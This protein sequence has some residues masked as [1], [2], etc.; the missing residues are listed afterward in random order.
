MDH[1]EVAWVDQMA[2]LVADP[3]ANQMITDGGA[4]QSQRQRFAS[5]EH[6]QSI[7]SIRNTS[8]G[9]VELAYK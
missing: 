9:E 6:T 3:R 2:D 1:W 5:G 4:R 8:G 7:F